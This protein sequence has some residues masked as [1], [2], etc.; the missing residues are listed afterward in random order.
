MI[1]GDD[2]KRKG[3]MGCDPINN[4][5]YFFKN[6]GGRGAT[7]KTTIPSLLKPQKP[8]NGGINN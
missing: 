7:P 4:D 5:H 6:E 1:G 8:K 2:Y 3:L